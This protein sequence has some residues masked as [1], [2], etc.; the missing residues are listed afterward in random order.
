MDGKGQIWGGNRQQFTEMDRI[1]PKLIQMDRNAWKWLEM[2]G[3]K[4]K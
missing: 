3:N 2:D 4:G 1:G